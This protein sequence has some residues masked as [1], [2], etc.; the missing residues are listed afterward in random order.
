[1]TLADPTRLVE[2]LAQLESDANDGAG[3]EQRRFRR[4]SVRAQARLEPVEG[5]SG[6][7]ES[8]AAMMR[9]VSRG[10]V[11]VVAE[12]PLPLGSVWRITFERKGR[13]VGSHLIVVLYCR[14][15]QEGAYMLGGQF[16]VEPALLLMLGVD[17]AALSDDIRLGESAAT[18]VGEAEFSPPDAIT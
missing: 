8:V 13:Q 10:G 1:M 11:G 4:F 18:D 16:I 17:D 6:E 2:I 9:N 3:A 15:I 5:R 14:R 7:L 12:R